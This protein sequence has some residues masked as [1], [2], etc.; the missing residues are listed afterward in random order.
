[1]TVPVCGLMPPQ[2]L[3]GTLLVITEPEAEPGIIWWAL[4]M[5]SWGWLVVVSDIGGCDLRPWCQ[6]RSGHGLHG[7]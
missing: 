6:Y 5:V 3:R 2:K 7:A 1:M 4:M